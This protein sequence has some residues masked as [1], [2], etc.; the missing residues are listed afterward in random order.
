MHRRIVFAVGVGALSFSSLCFA[1]PSDYVNTPNVE[2]GEREIDFKA[3]RANTQ[4]ADQQS[5]AS[6]GFG[7]G[8]TQRWFTEFYAK[9]ESAG[10][11]ATHFD[12]WEWENKFQLTETGQYPVDFGF[13]V[14]LERPQDHDEGY[15]V[16]FG[17]LFQSDFGKVQLNGNLLF[18]RNYR[19]SVSGPMQFGYQWQVKYRWREALEFGLQGFGDVGAWDDW[20]PSDQQSHRFGPAVFGK[21]PVGVHKA[22][23]YNAGLLL[24][25]SSGA[26]NNTFR[27]QIEYEF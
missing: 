19:A 20:D 12:A 17:P 26:P 9:Y 16:R 6:L 24:K 4:G 3:G 14:E 21:I 2:Y 18:E 7:Y 11:G 8:A 5:A 22:I 10:S 15:E 25:A 1:G 13:V 23:R 27:M